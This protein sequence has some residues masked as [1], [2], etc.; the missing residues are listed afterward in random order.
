MFHEMKNIDKHYQHLLEIFLQNWVEFE[1]F[2]MRLAKLLI[3][4]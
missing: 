1:F 4:V 3:E 2:K